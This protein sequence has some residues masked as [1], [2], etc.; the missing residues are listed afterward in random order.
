MRFCINFYSFSISEKSRCSLNSPA[1]VCFR[2]LFECKDL[3][4]IERR[5]FWQM[6]VLVDSLFR[7]WIVSFLE[8]ARIG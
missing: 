7:L 2:N 8:R 1:I 4:I 3:F 6:A 5:V